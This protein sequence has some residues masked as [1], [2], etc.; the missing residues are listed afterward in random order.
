VDSEP[1]SYQVANLQMRRDGRDLI[2]DQWDIT[3]TYGVMESVDAPIEDHLGWWVTGTFRTTEDDM[4]LVN[5]T[6]EWRGPGPAPALTASVV[7]ALRLEPLYRSARRHVEHQPG[8]FML[9]VPKQDRPGRKGRPD[10]DY[11]D[12]A[13][14]YVEL[15]SSSSK[16][17]EALAKQMNVSKSSA[18]SYVHEARR[19]GLLTKTR[20]GASGGK[21]T[22]KANQLLKEQGRCR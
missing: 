9:L 16:P 12:I 7:R 10:M 20:Q 4:T 11:A 2:P 1:T 17:I 6:I 15:L 14:H 21:L 8:P 19:R 22:E 18:S 5:V 3:D 13:H